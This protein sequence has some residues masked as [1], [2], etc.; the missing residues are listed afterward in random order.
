M[1]KPR[2]TFRF[3]LTGF[4]LLFLALGLALSGCHINPAVQGSGEAYLQ[5][6]WQQD[7]LAGRE[8]LL[9]Y[10]SADFTFTCD[11]FYVRINTTTKVKY[12]ADSCMGK[13]QWTEYAK[14][15]YEQK[16]DTLHLKGLFCNADYSIKSPG[17]CL[18][19]GVYEDF[20]R[21]TKKTDSVIQLSGSADMIPVDLHLIKRIACNPKPL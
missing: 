17:T 5:G 18:R 6:Q 20:L 1:F 15:H 19:V 8:K 16:N 21:V 10:A 11:S 9:T 13:G 2:D 12:V 14:G 3:L 4:P 7:S